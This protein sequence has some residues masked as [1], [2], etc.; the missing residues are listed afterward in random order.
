[1]P[2][3]VPDPRSYP[4]RPY[5]AVSAA[6]VHATQLLVVRRAQFPAAGVFTLPGGAVET[7]ETLVQAVHR[8]V[9]EETGLAIEPVDLV[10]HREV[11]V[12][13]SAGEVEQHFVVLVF[14]AR[15][16]AGEMLLS[17]E[18]AE[19]RWI[20]AAGLATL[21]TTEGLAAIASTA[22]KRLA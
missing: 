12:R 18:I 21:P 9:H 4:N 8:E 1:M 13:D 6:I 22:L 5:L 20:D 3:K 15:W 19:A 10:G 17:E 11:I 14:A 16:C 2:A 7:G